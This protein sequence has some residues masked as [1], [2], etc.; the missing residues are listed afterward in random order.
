MDNS[1]TTGADIVEANAIL[2]TVVLKGLNHLFRED[3]AKGTGL[4][5]GGDDVIHRG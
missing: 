1:L 5:L 3:I 2:L 4:V